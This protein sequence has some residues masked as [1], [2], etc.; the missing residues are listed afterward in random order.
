MTL[1]AKYL[2][3]LF[4]HITKTSREPTAVMAVNAAPFPGLPTAVVSTFLH[5]NK[6]SSSNLISLKQN[7]A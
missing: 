5:L 3:F 6:F 2:F 1:V 7:F 4:L